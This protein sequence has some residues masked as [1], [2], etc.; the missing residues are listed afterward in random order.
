MKSFVI[1]IMDNP[2]SVA[3]AERCIK[4]T[5]E[6]GT[7]MS[8][9]ITPKDNPHKIFEEEGLPVE[10][11]VE[12]YSYLESCMSAFL[13]HYNLWKF[14]VSKKQEVQ[15]FEHDAVAVSHLP[16]FISHKGCISLGQPSYGKF[17]YPEGLGPVDLM[18]KQYFPGAHAYRVKPI[19][20]R[21]LIEQAKID[22]GPT[23]IF[24]HNDR[25]P[26]LEEYYPWPVVAK[27]SFTTIQKEEG[28]L[29][30]HNWRGGER[31]E[32]IR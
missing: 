2:R 16:E 9:A 29:A 14:S 1:T 28:C 11:F 24:L 3:S 13:S 27:D 4:S 21:A 19:A 31:Y 10:N 7:V 18:S 12:K 30:K 17:N 32:I 23:D 15:I 8:P 6:F 5:K 22:A 26:F 20:A 25:F